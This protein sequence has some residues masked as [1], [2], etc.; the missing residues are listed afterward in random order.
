ML[1]FAL[2]PVAV[3]Q[4]VS[5]ETY[6]QRPVAGH[7]VFD[8]RAGVDTQSA[9]SH[10]YLCAEGYPLRWLSLEGCG[11]GSGFLHHGSEPEMAHFRARITGVH[12]A[13]GRVGLDGLV[14]AGFAE[15]QQGEDQIGFKFGKPT[16]TT[17]IEA[18]GPEA[19]V[20][21][22]GRLWLDQGG[23]TY[24]TGD[25]TGGAAVIAGAPEVLGHG[26]AAVPFGALTVGVGF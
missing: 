6:L 21:V 20:G 5:G 12:H 24:A 17:A 9:G 15:V 22:K 4:E 16:Q 23:R 2:A 3:A 13:W 10:P 26:G 14:G 18:A 11:T 19:S 1:A 25:L 8:F 7:P